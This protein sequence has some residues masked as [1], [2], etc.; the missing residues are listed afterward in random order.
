MSQRL[1]RGWHSHC[2][3][4][5]AHR[6]RWRSR[7]S[8]L[9]SSLGT[10]SSSLITHPTVR[11][12]HNSLSLTARCSRGIGLELTRQLLESPANFIIATARDPTKATALQGLKE[13]A[14]GTLRV[15]QLDVDDE[16]GIERSYDEVVSIL[17]D[18]GLDYLVNNAAVVRPS[19]PAPSYGSVHDTGEAH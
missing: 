6:K 2:S 3:L 4:L 14:R 13:T 11:A 8:T 12:A 9:G 17:G 16:H 15:I 7:T 10:T 19:A 1:D 5:T 18:R